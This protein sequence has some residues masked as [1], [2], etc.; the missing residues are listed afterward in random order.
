MLVATEGLSLLLELGLLIFC[1]IDVI[2]S[3]DIDIRHLPKAGWLLLVII[4]PLIGGVAWLV[5]GR[6]IRSTSRSVSWPS[7]PT[8]GFPEYERPRSATRAPDDDPR[9]LAELGRVNQEHENTLRRWEEDLRRREERLRR[10][11]GADPDTGGS[12]TGN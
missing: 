12:P 7:G 11:Q 5:A 8:A 6:P 4:L 3:P 2:Q 9:F 10:E 1:V